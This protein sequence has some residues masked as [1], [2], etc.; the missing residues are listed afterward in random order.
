[1]CPL[2]LG[3]LYSGKFLPVPSVT[4]KT[5]IPK[6]Q[7]NFELRMINDKSMNEDRAN[8]IEWVKKSATQNY[9]AA[10]DALKEL[11]AK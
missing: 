8:G 2:R 6:A 3:N 10:I 7:M 1:M 11:G 4:G 9:Q 5:D